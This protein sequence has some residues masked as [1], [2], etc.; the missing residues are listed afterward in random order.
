MDSQLTDYVYECKCIYKHVT[1]TTNSGHIKT[2]TFIGIHT[3][4]SSLVIHYILEQELCVVS[5]RPL[6]H[7]PVPGW[8]T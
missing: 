8:E 2:F 5:Q 1:T 4:S 6:G 7:G 3:L